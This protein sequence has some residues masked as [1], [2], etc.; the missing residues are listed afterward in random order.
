MK[1]QAVRMIFCLW[2][3][4]LLLPNP[5]ARADPGEHA[6]RV[7]AVSPT[8]NFPRQAGTAILVAFEDKHYILTALHVVR[9]G[10]KLLVQVGPPG[11]KAPPIYYYLEDLVDD[12]FRVDPATDVCAFRCTA[13]K[14]K[15]LTSKASSKRPIPLR[16]VQVQAGWQVLALGNPNPDVIFPGAK[17]QLRFDVEN[18]PGPGTVQS[19]QTAGD[20]FPEGV[21]GDARTTRLVFISHPNAIKGGFSGGPVLY[22]RDGGQSY[23]LVGMV[24]GGDWIAENRAWAITTGDLIK[25][26]RSGR[27]LHYPP[28]LWP[29]IQLQISVDKPPAPPP[30]PPGLPANLGDIILTGLAPETRTELERIGT[31]QPGEVP[32]PKKPLMTALKARYRDLAAKPT[33]SLSDRYVYCVLLKALTARK[34]EDIPVVDVKTRNECEEF[35]NNVQLGLENSAFQ[36]S[37][38]RDTLEKERQRVQEQLAE[39][40]TKEQGFTGL[41]SHKLYEA[42]EARKRGDLQAAAGYYRDFLAVALNADPWARKKVAV[43]YFEIADDYELQQQPDKAKANQYRAVGWLLLK[44]LPPGN[45]SLTDFDVDKY[46]DLTNW[47]PKVRKGELNISVNREVSGNVLELH[48]HKSSFSIWQIV[49]LQPDASTLL[50]WE[51]RADKVPIWGKRIEPGQTGENPNAVHPIQVLVGLLR[52]PDP[53]VIHYCWNGVSGEDAYWT[54]RQKVRLADLPSDLSEDLINRSGGFLDPSDSISLRYEIIVVTAG[55]PCKKW[56]PV[57]RRIADDFKRFHPNEDLP[58]IRLIGVQATDYEAPA[59]E[60]DAD[61]FIRK[62][63]FVRDGAAPSVEK[64]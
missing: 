9:T 31:L 19:V 1:S 13:A 3:V 21:K 56:I 44:S 39:V 33:L 48:C 11:V 5:A 29:D 17:G 23:E 61:A 8:S 26:I 22:S 42:A 6:L 63:R 46:G 45:Q 16:P 43:G 49:K 62:L 35:L 58:E 64:R 60:D 15:E 25:A 50:E 24:E 53:I 51:W 18:I 38:K 12:T 47:I 57:R 34:E 32:P 52:F 2:L 20:V 4:A 7:L 14:F 37:Q 54:E 59:A 27:V 30:Q 10:G 36:L 40:E 41:S 55:G 28:D